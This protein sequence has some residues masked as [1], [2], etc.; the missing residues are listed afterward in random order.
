MIRQR[1]IP[2][3]VT[4]AAVVLCLSYAK[5]RSNLPHWWMSYG[6]GIPYVMFW[7][8]LWFTAFPKK[9]WITAICIGVV[10][11]TCFL[12]VAQLWNPEPLA[13]FRRTRF[14]AALLGSTFVWGDF[15]PY[16]MGGV[17]GWMVL[18]GIPIL[19]DKTDTKSD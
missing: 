16:F 13:S 8:A 7:I 18:W 9:K 15:P 10:A 12:E 19:K 14:G 6:G 11:F 17:I 1:I 4:L 3:F 2:L 5:F